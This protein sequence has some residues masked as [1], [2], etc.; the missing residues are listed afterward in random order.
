MGRNKAVGPDFLPDNLPNL[1]HFLQIVHQTLSSKE[2]IQD[3]LP[4]HSMLQ[5]LFS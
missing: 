2:R 5:E 4:Q 3:F 1:N